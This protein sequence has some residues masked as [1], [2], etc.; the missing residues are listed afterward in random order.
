M[1]LS[2]R[3]ALKALVVIPGT[4]GGLGSS[5]SS[6]LQAGDPR[7]EAED[8]T[9]HAIAEIVIPAEADRAAATRR[10]AEWIANYREGADTDHGYGN[11]RVR[12]TGPSPSRNYPAQV[13][14]LDAAANTRGA[15]SFAAATVEQRR[16]ILEAAIT[17]AKIERL[18]ARPTG[19]HIATDLMGHYFGS[20]DAND[21]C[22]NVAIGRD[23]CR[24]L[25]GSEQAPAP[26]APRL[27]PR[28]SRP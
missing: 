22:Y 5:G 10:F 14:A 21:L 11:T 28:P 25:A 12:P 7:L 24:G 13:A 16:A 23:A 27:A 4:A 1:S 6:S 15:A 9:L 3:D 26:R 20:S 2:R 19:G 8:P 18:S 17:E